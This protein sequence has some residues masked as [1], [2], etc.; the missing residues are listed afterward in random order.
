MKP[1]TPTVLTAAVL[2]A[3]VG[4]IL[5][6]GAAS[7]STA[8]DWTPAFATSADGARIAYYAMPGAPD[9]VP[10][11][12]ISGGPGSDHRYMHAGGAF[13]RLSEQRRVVMFDQRATGRSD[14]APENPRIDQWVADVEAIRRALGAGRIDLLGHSFGGYL[15]MSYAV[16]HPERARSLVLVDSAAPD[17]A[18]NVQLL[19]EVYPERIEG[20]SER[21]A[22]LPDKFPAEAISLFFSMEFVDPAWTDRYLEHVRG[23]TYDISVNDALRADME[24]RSL[25]E[26]IREIDKPVL[27]LHGRFD[28]VLA[29]AT[30]WAIHQALPRSRFQVLEKSGHMPFI[31]QPD[32]FVAAV[33][34][35]LREAG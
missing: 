6:S 32:A 5:A 22:S 23:L 12:V 10:L 29:P 11:L 3:A 4:L 1:K 33:S 20:W 16:A 21:R 24:A 26:H 8:R 25:G 19:G 34:E 14:P 30:S 18:Q 28:G 35:F 27:V 15:A 9:T 2:S 13:E 31:E 17:P 7:Q